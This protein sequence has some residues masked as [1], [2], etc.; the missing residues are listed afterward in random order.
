MYKHGKMEWELKN[1]LLLEDSKSNKL[2][3]NSKNKKKNEKMIK[4]HSGATFIR[5][6]VMKLLWKKFT[7]KKVF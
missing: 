6:F 7:E 5:I 1:F 3:N 4:T 2:R